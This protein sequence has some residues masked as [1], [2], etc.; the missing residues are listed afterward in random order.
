[1]APNRPEQTDLCGKPGQRLLHRAWQQ[2]RAMRNRTPV[3]A[4]WWSA[5]QS[6]PA[7]NMSG[8]VVSATAHGTAPTGC[9]TRSLY[10]SG[11]GGAETAESLALCE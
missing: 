9:A 5:A 3:A 7:G 8:V 4:H 11:T 1:M 10:G 2:V 6:T